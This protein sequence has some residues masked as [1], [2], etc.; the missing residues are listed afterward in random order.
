[1]VLILLF[2]WRHLPKLFIGVIATSTLWQTYFIY[3]HPHRFYDLLPLSQFD[4]FGMGALLAYLPF[5]KKQLPWL[6]NPK[7]APALFVAITATLIVILNFDWPSPLFN[8]LF[9]ACA[10][11]LIHRAQKGFKGPVGWLLNRPVI[12]YLGRI[13]YGLYVY[14]LFMPWLWNCLAGTQGRYRLPIAIFTNPWMHTVLVNRI[15]QSILL[16]GIASLSWFFF[17]KP[18]IKLKNLPLRKKKQPASAIHPP[19]HEIQSLPREGKNRN[20]L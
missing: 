1:M 9:S 14:H 17:E 2:K 16:L 6:E 3:I 8:L 10:L 12:I 20:F 19:A 5:S 13:S 15:A 11:L 7:I 4:T 18:L